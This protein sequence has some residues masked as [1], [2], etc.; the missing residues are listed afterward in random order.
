MEDSQIHKCLQCNVFSDRVRVEVE[1]R[2]ARQLAQRCDVGD[3]ALGDVEVREARELTQRTDVA[4]RVAPEVQVGE[5]R[6]I[7]DPLQALDLGFRSDLDAEAPT[8][9]RR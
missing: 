6:E 7:L 9:G 5:A 8:R 2:Q 4:D 3:G 1:I